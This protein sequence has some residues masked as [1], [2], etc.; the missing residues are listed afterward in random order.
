MWFKNK[1]TGALFEVVDENMIERL[2]KSDEFQEGKDPTVKQEVKE[3][4]KSKTYRRNSK[5]KEE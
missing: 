4:S 1:N 2:K 3:E 5:T